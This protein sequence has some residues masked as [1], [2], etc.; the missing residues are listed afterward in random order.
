MGDKAGAMGAGNEAAV[1]PETAFVLDGDDAR[2][3][4]EV[5]F[6]AAGAGDVARAGIVF[7]ALRRVRPG[8][9]Y[10]L[11][12]LAVAHMNAGQAADAVRLLEAAP[13]ADDEERGLMQAWLGLAL[14]VEGRRGESQRVLQSA[15]TAQGEGAALARRLLGMNESGG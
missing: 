4:T 2:F 14:Q 10:P 11:I 12:G 13:A 5:G 6:L 8:R 15:A 9:A 1:S 3:L 7:G